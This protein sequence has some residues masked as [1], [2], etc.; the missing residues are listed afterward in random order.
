MAVSDPKG[1]SKVWATLIGVSAVCQTVTD[2][3]A[4]V[5]ESSERAATSYKMLFVE[6]LNIQGTLLYVSNNF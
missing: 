2:A 4:V 1:G 3:R 6:N 5:G